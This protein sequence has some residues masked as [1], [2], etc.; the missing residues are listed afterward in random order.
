MLFSPSFSR[1]AL[2]VHRSLYE[3][4]RCVM[5]TCQEMVIFT[6]DVF[7][8]WPFAIFFYLHFCSQLHLR[9]INGTWHLDSHRVG[10][11]CAG[12]IWVSGVPVEQIWFLPLLC[13]RSFWCHSVHLRLFRKYDFENATP[14]VRVFFTK[15]FINIS[16]DNSHKITYWNFEI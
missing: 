2:H 11:N 9:T 8:P 15:H 3:L 12:E 7:L 5:S 1:R 6:R 13:Q 14:T 4:Q 10:H 16:C